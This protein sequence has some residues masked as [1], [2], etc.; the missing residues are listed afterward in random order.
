MDHLMNKNTRTPTQRRSGKKTDRGFARG[1][2]LSRATEA[3]ETGAL[4]AGALEAIALQ[5]GHRKVPQ[6]G[7]GGLPGEQKRSQTFS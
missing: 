3:L 4:E 7:G 6:I 5:A 2:P 1:S